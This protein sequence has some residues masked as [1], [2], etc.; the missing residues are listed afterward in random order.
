V[1]IA[2]EMASYIGYT[3]DR[4]VVYQRAVYWLERPSHCGRPGFSSLV[5]SDQKNLK[6]CYSQLPYLTFITNGLGASREQAGKFAY[7]GT[8]SLSKAF[9]GMPLIV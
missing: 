7:C 9:K 5:E 3:R 2:H 8:L 1:K 4:I 6:S